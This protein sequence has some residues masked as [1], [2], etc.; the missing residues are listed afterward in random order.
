MHDIGLPTV[1]Y[2]RKSIKDAAEDLGASERNTRKARDRLVAQGWLERIPTPGQQKARY[3][4]A[5]PPTRH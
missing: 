3:K 5:F 1:G 2:V 4:I